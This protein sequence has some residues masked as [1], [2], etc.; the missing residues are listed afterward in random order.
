M[1]IV[2]HGATRHRAKNVQLWFLP[3]SRTLRTLSTLAHLQWGVSH[4][5][6]SC[7][8]WFSSSS[9]AADSSASLSKL[10][11]ELIFANLLLVMICK[12]LLCL[13]S[14]LSSVLEKQK[15]GINSLLRTTCGAFEN[16]PS[17]QADCWDILGR[18][19]RSVCGTYRNVF[20][21]RWDVSVPRETM[22]ATM[23]RR[24]GSPQWDI[25]LVVPE[26]S[27]QGYLSQVA[28][29]MAFFQWW[30][31]TVWQDRLL[32]AVSRR[33]MEEFTVR[34]FTTSTRSSW[35]VIS[36]FNVVLVQS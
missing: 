24:T 32:H 12:G 1:E 28:L 6:C 10:T 9:P 25:L 36:Q 15:K 8:F 20:L 17:N 14:S 19:H 23:M 22:S 4:V 26:L 11:V 29:A 2:S 5:W 18:I 33:P 34:N 30:A 16:P 21:V 27:I 3:L 7:V 31:L 35:W 13:I